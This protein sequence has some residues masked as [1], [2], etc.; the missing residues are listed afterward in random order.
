ML[1]CNS[2]PLKLCYY[3]RRVHID[4]CK[5]TVWRLS[6]CLSVFFLS[7]CPFAIGVLMANKKVEVIFK[8]HYFDLLWI[9]CTISWT[10][11]IEVMKFE[12]NVVTASS[13]PT[14]PVYVTAP[15]IRRP[16][17]LLLFCEKKHRLSRLIYATSHCTEH[18]TASA[19]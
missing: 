18:D 7:V 10:Q 14:R 1:H 3:S 13:A 17:E 9:C 2:S 12:R 19:L 4:K 15:F 5:A 6:V 8:L 16:S 11:Q